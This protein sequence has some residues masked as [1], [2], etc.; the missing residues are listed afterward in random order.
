MPM[1][2]MQQRQLAQIGAATLRWFR[3]MTKNEK[4]GPWKYEDI[5]SELRRI[6]E[7]D[8]LEFQFEVTNETVKIE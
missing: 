2:Q 8:Q 7:E 5:D 4:K 6:F 3:E 1:K